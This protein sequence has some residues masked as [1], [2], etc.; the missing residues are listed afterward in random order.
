MKVALMAPQ[1]LV[2]PKGI[3]PKADLAPAGSFG[4]LLKQKLAEVN[5]L[6]LKADELTRQMLAGQP[7]DLH[8]VMI[9]AEQ[10]S[11]ALQLTVQIRNKVIEAYQEVSRMQI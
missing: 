8:Q 3:P 5:S 7:V 10:A 4:D 2:L 6:Q 1:S 9:A 11:L